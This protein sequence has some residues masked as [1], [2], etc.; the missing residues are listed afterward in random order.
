MTQNSRS[1]PETKMV[2]R[3]LTRRLALYFATAFLIA[4]M[5]GIVI[6]Q[7]RTRQAVAV[8][9]TEEMVRLRAD[10]LNLLED[11]AEDTIDLAAN[12]LVQDYAAAL[13]DDTDNTDATEENVLRLFVNAISTRLTSD[14]ISVRYLDTE[15]QILV[16]VINVEGVPS[17]A[18]NPGRIDPTGF[19]GTSYAQ[20]LA[21]ARPNQIYISQI[22][23][24]EFGGGVVDVLYF[25]APVM[26]GS[27]VAGLVQLGVSVNPYR[28]LLN[29]TQ[30]RLLVEPGEYGVILIDANGRPLASSS[31]VTRRDTEELGQ[32]LAEVK[33]NQTSL[34][35]H[36]DIGDGYRFFF[37]S[38]TEYTGAA[39]P[40][41]VVLVEDLPYVTQQALEVM[42]VITILVFLL[43]V[44]AIYSITRTV[45]AALEPIERLSLKAQTLAGVRDHTDE[46]EGLHTALEVISQ[47]VSL[48]EAQL[49]AQIFRYTRD[50]EV[51]GRIGREMVTVQDVDQL[52]NQA[53]NLICDEYGFFHAQVFVADEVRQNL[54]LLYSRGRSGE[55]ML[56]SG[57]Q[58]SV[59]SYS[60][61]AAVARSRQAIIINDVYEEDTIPFLPNPLLP[62]T[63][64]EM[65]LPLLIEG[66]ILGVLDIHSMEPDAF[67]SDEVPT[68]Q[69]IADQLAV[70]LYS[71]RLV[72]QSEERVHQINRLNRRLTRMAW[73]EAEQRIDISREYRYN[74]LD[75]EVRDTPSE[76]IEHA[77]TTP[78]NI[79][80]EI[81][82]TINVE[83]NHEHDLSEGDQLV[84]QSVAE[85]IAL[86]LD[87]AR[88]FQ[89]TQLSLQDTET[90]YQLTRYLN[91]ANTLEDILQAVFYAVMPEA[92]GGQVWIFDDVEEEF[93]PEW[94]EVVSDVAV[95][96][97]SV[98]LYG[99]RLNMD[100]YPFLRDLATESVTL[101]SDIRRSP[102]L[103]VELAHLFERLNA[104][105]LV[106]IPLK[107]RGQ[108]RGIFT[109]QFAEPRQFTEREER[110]YFALIDQAGVAI[111]NRLLL[112]QSQE[113]A[114]R[115]ENLY[116]ASRKINQAR[117][118][119]D[120]VDAVALVNRDPS[121]NFSLIIAEGELDSSGW[122]TRARTVAQTM[123][124]EVV[125]V[126]ELAPLHIPYTSPLR[127]RQ[128]QILTDDIPE[129]M[130][131][132]DEIKA[133]RKQGLR[134]MA[135]F[136]LLSSNQLIALFRI[137]S[138]A[139]YELSF[140]DYEFYHALTGLMSSQIQ[141]RRQQQTTEATLEETR[142][143]YRAISALLRAQTTQDVYE[144]AIE[145][146]AAFFIQADQFQHSVDMFVWLAQPQ[147]RPDAPM[148]KCVYAWNTDR[149][150]MEDRLGQQ[151]LSDYYP[152][153]QLTTA[154]GGTIT[155]GSIG[156][157]RQTDEI[158]VV[159]SF[160]RERLL[161][162]GVDSLVAAPMRS[163]QRW[164]GVIICQSGVPYAFTE[165]FI[166]FLTAIAEQIGL[167]VEGLTLYDEAR[168][169]AERAQDEAQRNLALVEA[170]Q[171]VSRLTENRDE[172]EDALADGLARVAAQSGM[173]R[174]L[175]YMRSGSYL[176]RKGGFL[177]GADDLA[178]PMYQL[179]PE[180]PD[181]GLPL[182]DVMTLDRSLLV[183]DP[184]DYLRISGYPADDRDLIAFGFGKHFVV[185]IRQAMRP[186]GVLLMGQSLERDDLDEGAE[187]L[188]NTLAAQIVGGLENR[189]LF[190]N[191]R[192]EQRNLSAI[193]AT[194]PAGVIVLDPKTL[195]PREFNEQAQKHFGR[196]IEPDQPFTIESYN[197]HRTGTQILYPSDEM[198]IY[199]ALHTGM[200]QT[201]DDV[202]V[203]LP[204]GEQIDLLLDVAPITDRY[205]QINSLIVATQDISRLRKL[206]N[207][208]QETLRETVSL[209]EAQRA[210]T[211]AG[212]LESLLDAIFA[213]MVLLGPAEAAILLT[214]EDGGL[215]TVRWMNAPMPDYTLLREVLDPLETTRVANIEQSSLSEP[216]RNMF[217]GLGLRAS[218]SI[219][220]RTSTRSET[221]GWLFVALDHTNG[222]STSQE[223]LLFQ[224]SDLAATAVDN[225]YLIRSQQETLGQI[226]ALYTANAAIRAAIGLPDLVDALRDSL[227]F[228]EPDYYGMFLSP[229][230][231]LETGLDGIMLN[232]A[233]GESTLADVISLLEGTAVSLNGV[234]VEDLTK[235][236]DRLPYEE[237]LLAA[238]VR[239]YA[240][241][242]LHPRDEQEGLVL[243]AFQTPRRFKDSDRNYLTALADTTSI[244]LYNQILIEE[245][246]SNL[247]EA[248][249]NYQA[250]RYLT[251]AVTNQ[252]IVDVLQNYLVRPHINNVYMAALTTPE[253]NSPN[254]GLQMVAAWNLGPVVNLRSAVLSRE[255]FPAWDL[256]A[257]TREE[258]LMVDDVL[259][260]P[261]LTDDER[262][263]LSTGMETRSF[264]ILPLRIQNHSYGIIWVG[265][266]QPYRHT[267]R[268]A[269]SFRSFAEQA[270]IK[271]EAAFLLQQTERRARQLQTSAAVSSNVSSILDLDVLLPR[272][273]N[274]IQ[275]SFR[276]QHVQVFLMDS[277]GDYAVLRA[278][279]GEAGRQLLAN[280]HRLAK[281][282]ASVI[283]QVTLQQ[284]PQIAAD[285]ADAD[286]VHY[287][288]PFL[289][290]TR[291]EMALPLMVKGE[292]VG[293]LDV[294]SNRPNAFTDE[295]VSVLTTLAAQISVAIDNA[296]L[297]EQAQ[298]Q[299]SE[300]AFQFALTTSIAYANTLDEALHEIVTRL[301]GFLKALAVVIYLPRYYIDS[302]DNTYTILEAAAG[303]G[304]QIPLERVGEVNASDEN[305]LIAIISKSRSPFRVQDIDTEPNY[306]RLHPQSRAA[307]LI[308][309]NSANE[310]IGL[311]AIETLQTI[312]DSDTI[313]LL[314]S[315]SGTVS[316]VVQSLMLLDELTDKNTQLQELDRLKS[317]FLANMS[318][319]LRTPLNSIIGF[320]RVMLKEI[321]GPL[322]EMQ[323]QDLNTIY[324]AGQHLLTLINSIL[325]Q[326]KIAAGKLDLK[327]EYFEP[328][329]LI[330]AVKSIGIGLV[331]D[332]PISIYAE[333]A[334]NLPR[335]YGDEF[336][337]SQILLNLVSNAA[338]FTQAGQIV[339]RA[340]PYLED[341]DELV[342]RVD[343]ED[344]GIGI[345]EK[346][347]PLL[348]EAFR[349][350]DSS[351]TRTQGGTGLGLNIARSL[352]ELQGGR[353]Y[354][355]SQLA[356]GSTFSITIPTSAK[357]ETEAAPA[358][359]AD[360]TLIVL[361]SVLDAITDPKPAT[362]ATRPSRPPL[363]VMPNR[364]MERRILLIEENKDIVDRFRQV[365][366]REGYEV[367]TADHP[368]YAE[369]MAS[370][371]RPTLIIMD[372]NFGGGEGWNILRNLK[373]RD[374]T[375]DIPV[376]V[377]T[378]N[379]D[380]ERAYQ[381]G[382]HQF[383]QRPFAPEDLVRAAREAEKESQTERILI[384]DDDPAS[385]RLLTQLL[386][387]NGTYRIFSAENGVDG[388]SMV[389]RRRPD[390][391]ILDLRMP[392]MDGFAVLEELRAN[393]ETSSIPV[394]VVTGDLDLE[395]DEQAQLNH[396][397]VLSKANLNDAEYDEFIT[398]IRNHLKREK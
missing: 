74:L 115:N 262:I 61:I 226:Q 154:V 269:R 359:E 18:S 10:V 62:E 38:I 283:G 365:L 388:I 327:L 264:A 36:Y 281:G 372:V 219:P 49:Q 238:G 209:Y 317:E 228:L 313:G 130:A 110:V 381:L 52:L 309:M 305:N 30:P 76:P 180:S 293:A 231:G 21:N 213:Q 275:Q 206:E 186:V 117:T 85:R 266:D 134:F 366:Q 20:A 34:P 259:R 328:R 168:Y 178:K 139:H 91:E 389:A 124:R 391:I 64:S 158:L 356:I 12:L 81:I 236:A 277:T 202:A 66:Q 329:P 306:R 395:A 326:A 80:G 270:S 126:D 357:I 193:L 373:D 254:A 121:L 256:M 196:E 148:L 114:T 380:S 1:V 377:V 289:P 107:V 336:R 230:T 250:S 128:P 39:F 87:N 174:W 397:H 364:L 222:L 51:A 363:N 280:R 220:L 152:Y 369:A 150:V 60:L 57:L 272:I 294:Q 263:S 285:T 149:G 42:I 310:S 274:L 323:E 155:F 362:P 40:W 396:I 385:I 101:L 135:T 24:T 182:V 276:Y 45:G 244:V 201:A 108:W 164:F 166:Q 84:I 212:D 233:S 191:V 120:L 31:N 194:L 48:L 271:L 44:G 77:I 98:S 325:D 50:F 9:R 248:S 192:N 291:S 177:P 287:P 241:M 315:L 390:L 237:A 100:A 72:S 198:P 340:Y 32:I 240:V 92:T 132:P 278:S 173:D 333:I 338:K 183:N 58:L 300:T 99:T 161:D 25:Y 257:N 321:D 345:A 2:R 67:R 312:T 394:M 78:I 304:L 160:L 273:V 398:K 243:A 375:F 6:V 8:Q 358:E 282:S 203:V 229:E 147:P 89:Q 242:Q 299:A 131:V 353:M 3:Y 342:L 90:L 216:V 94:V 383:I 181:N 324:K 316:A 235:Q 151:L 339:I 176:E 157:K 215:E 14:Y 136:P 311:I 297:Y 382:A 374:D 133:M 224:F 258:V 105:A 239:A 47:Q 261:R 112:R 184:L 234:F 354:L 308:P 109:A 344:T 129:D 303:A 301:H 330:E 214:T 175:F 54:L 378:L 153:G 218:L 232:E 140:S 371:V 82:G 41:T 65:A 111:D 88:L 71:A 33:E 246:Q 26:R 337:T 7:I 268:E 346:D 302:R 370:N 159:D 104:R 179:G 223:S 265:S 43:G 141:I 298:K 296:R 367:L 11:P 116:A 350:V 189:N 185:P 205:G 252:D 55:M 106:F 286:V 319:E 211:E 83:P 56:E 253:W 361:D 318:H 113:D 284:T 267:D 347:Q 138:T 27:E 17:A 320:S 118:M 123:G 314:I 195:I 143:L 68:F 16:E 145:H 79:R 23:F 127:E 137:T 119:R 290:L 349:Q 249:S 360:D 188:V 331:K 210:L 162:E 204:D 227:L 225:R 122:P 386:N 70:A 255:Q 144:K 125:E 384:I 322:T 163:R 217:R 171:L 53:I 200:D 93:T 351:L 348:F 156:D 197:I 207:T 295:D 165:Q 96:E 355:E 170:S 379:P 142:R 86:A 22:A 368:A 343:I 190:E 387:K 208:L 13:D 288:N 251:N 59:N 4:L 376:I 172:F 352:V 307:M 35:D 187:Q 5:A 29:A 332:K 73:E 245:A 335:V 393:P 95:T 63:R 15:N 102:E 75:V 37:Y 247:E 28:T 292:I 279:T 260:D 334:P 392:G 221:L 46:V 19:V 169:E 199:L 146:I 341:D 167:T 97:R 103:D 69:L